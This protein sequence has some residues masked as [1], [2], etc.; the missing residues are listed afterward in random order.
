MW[1]FQKTDPFDTISQT[2]YVT[3]V[4]AGG[5]SSLIEYFASR[6]VGAGKSVV[7]TTTTKIWAKEPCVAL[8]TDGYDRLGKGA[9]L[10]VGGSCEGGK[11]TAAD[12]EDILEMGRLY[13]LVLIEGDGAK[14]RPLKVP[15][16]YEPVIPAFSERVFVVSG[17]DALAGRVSERVFR[18]ELLPDIA[19][20]DDETV[21][22]K[23][24]F[25]RFFSDSLL[26]KGIRNGTGI[27]V[28][29]KYDLAANRMGIA[30]L[31]REV[32]SAVGDMSVLVSSVPFK[33]FYLLKAT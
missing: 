32:A 12:D 20:I 10:R 24:F 26:L 3:F 29:N 9:F 23:E 27:V 15:A 21:V 14:G 16:P 33:I 6:A 7:V 19:G 4:G 5:K 17:L 2:K 13:D 18:W 8:R 30:T 31:A 1:H 11:L 22:T 25:L 28:L